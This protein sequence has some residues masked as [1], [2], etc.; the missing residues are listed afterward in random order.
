VTRHQQNG[1]RSDAALAW[2]IPAVA[3]FVLVSAC[4]LWLGADVSG[5][6]PGQPLGYSRAVISGRAPLP[7]PL[8]WTVT[9]I[10]SG[11]LIAM[12]WVVTWR[13]TARYGRSHR[14]DAVARFLAPRRDRVRLGPRARSA[15]AA[16]L[17]P[18]AASWT[19][20]PLGRIVP[21]RRLASCGPEDV[22]V[23]VWGT[24]SGKTSSQVIPAILDAPGPVLATSNKRDVSD[25]T[26]A[27][28]ARRGKV[29]L[30]DPQGLASDGAPTFTYNPLG[31]VADAAAAQRLAAIFEASTREPGARTD[32][33]WDTAGRDLLA[34]LFLAA[35]AHGLPIGQV[36][37]WLSNPDD[38]APSLLLR[39]TGHSGPAT[40]VEGVLGQPDKMRGSTYGTAQRMARALVNPS[41]LAWVTP[42]A[43]LPEF[44][45]AA[46]PVSRDTLYALSREG[47]GSGGPFVAALTAHVCEAAE[48]HAAA[49]PAGRLAVPMV[50]ELDGQRTSS[51]GPNCPSCTATTGRAASCCTPTSSPGRWAPRRGASTGCA[52]CGRR[53]PSGA[54]RWD[55]GREVPGRVL[56]ADRRPRGLGA[57]VGERRVARRPAAD[58]VAAEGTRARRVRP[59]IP[60]QEPGDRI[61]LRRAPGG[62]QDNTV[63]ER[64][65]CGRDPGGGVMTAWVPALS[66]PGSRAVLGAGLAVCGTVCW[67]VLLF[68]VVGQPSS[69]P[70]ESVNTSQV[71]AAYLPWVLSAGALCGVIT[72]AVIAAQD[73][74][75]SDWNP[76]V[77]SSAGA[78]GIAQFL[79]G[80]FA[81]WGQD[82]DGTGDVSPFNPADEIMAQGRYDCSLASLMS[83]LEGA[84]QV[85]GD[86]LSLALAAYNAGPGA[87][88]AAHGVPGDAAGYAQSIESLA[89]TKYAGTVAAGS[90]SGQV[91][92]AAAES[93]LG[94]PYQWGGSCTDPHGPD[95]SAWCD[96]SSLV[97]M[98]W[99][100]AGVSLPRTTFA[101]V[102]VGTPV[103]SIADLQPGT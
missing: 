5:R 52:P 65:A 15:E 2:T 76:R 51:A 73:Q 7:G 77:V 90:G 30:F 69:S 13:V 74:V 16:R 84:G 71:P 45:P 25:V 93:A 64:A 32:A 4:V 8:G 9:G 60:A 29:W 55:R 62:D 91:A 36:W 89:S 10:A 18:G 59:G 22:S 1:P 66:Q 24:R 19:G 79:P 67:L 99:A 57:A 100:A 39:Q 102:D 43:G 27:L 98:A 47:E 63:D 88:E 41:L 72:P 37:E 44:D 53:R 48:R 92:V 23:H 20:T 28:R 11:V 42:V 6:R 86:V 38:A 31:V 3:L 49:V 46:F 68:T 103:A 101:Q 85:S 35:A 87:V 96:C 70:S 34:W 58:A 14:A 56:R 82:S 50:V 80:T 33:Q 75:E 61:R 83:A 95:P 21:G 97:Q 94:T 78:E 12:A 40:A 54:R 26:A 17:S 81:T